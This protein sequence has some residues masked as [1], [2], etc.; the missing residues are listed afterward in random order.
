MAGVVI[1]TYTRNLRF[2]YKRV[3]YAV[4]QLF[5]D[6]RL[7]LHLTK[8]GATSPFCL[9]ASANGSD[10]IFTVMGADGEKGY[11]AHFHFRGGRLFQRILNLSFSQNGAILIRTN[12]A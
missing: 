8:G 9:K 5:V 1:R 7:K 3:T 12:D 11:T 10:V 4:P 2:T 6:D